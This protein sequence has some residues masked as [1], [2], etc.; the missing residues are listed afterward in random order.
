MPRSSDSGKDSGVELIPQPHG[1]ALLPGGK[2]GNKG[3]PGRTPSALRRGLRQLLD[4]DG[5]DVLKGVLQ[6]RVPVKMVG[7]CTKC[8]T[9][10]EDYEFLPVEGMLIQKPEVPDRLRAIDIASKYGIGA[11]KAG[12]DEE[13]IDALATV[14]GQTA[15]ELLGEQADAFIDEIK[16]KWVP[17][18]ARKKMDG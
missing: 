12:Y 1:G 16:A 14:T 5:M 17:I 9:E 6:G 18:L 7:Q 11:A 13:L 15:V 4:D 3:G 2:K 8:G 10:H